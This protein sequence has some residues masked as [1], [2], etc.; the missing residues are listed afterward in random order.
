[1]HD[2]L[3]RAGTI[4]D[5]SGAAAFTSNVA[6]DNG[7]RTSVNGTLNQDLQLN[8]RWG[9]TRGQSL[10]AHNSIKV[11]LNSGLY[12]RAGTNFTA[13]GLA[14]QHHGEPGFD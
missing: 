12:A 7:R 9:A 2:L 1:M 8:T 11:Y 6:I 10:D 13:V 5:G 4:V 3:I 14:W